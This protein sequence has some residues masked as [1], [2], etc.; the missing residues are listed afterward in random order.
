MA[1]SEA[2]ESPWRRPFEEVRRALGGRRD[3]SGVVGSINWLRKQM[4]VRGANPN[5]VRNIIYRD[6]GKVADKR[7]L[8]AVLGELWVSTGKPPLRAPELELLLSAPPEGERE[9]LLLGREKRRVYAGFVGAVRAGKHPKLL[10]TG[11]QGS[12]KTLLIDYIQG[13]LEGLAEMSGKGVSGGGAS[14][15]VVRQEFSAADLAAGLLQLALAFGVSTEVFGAKLA[16][17]GVAGAYAVQ[18]DAQADV[19][20]VVLEHLKQPSEPLTLLLHVSQSFSGGQDTLLGAPLRLSTPDVPR[21]AMTEWLW[22]TLLEPVSRLTHVGLLV[23]MAD[24]PLTLAGRTDAFD[25]PVKLSPPTVNEARRFV[26]GRAQH[27]SAEQQEALVGRAKRSFEDL[28]TLTLLAEAREP[29]GDGR[30]TEQLGQL[31][32]SSSDAR[33]KDFL[34]VLAVLALPEYPAVAQRDLEALREAEPPALN[35]LEL[36]FLDAVP[37]EPGYWRP[38]ARLFSRTLRR[39]LK[40]A[41]PER[42]RS[43][44]LAASRLYADTAHSAPRSDAAGRFVHHLFAAR[45]WPELNAWAEETAVPQSLL[46]RLWRAAQLELQPHNT[47]TFEA[48]ALQVANYYV[49]L[50]SAEHPDAGQALAVLAASTD[51]KRRAW[52]LLKRAESAVLQGRF[53]HA[54]TL[55]QGWVEVDDPVLTVEAALVRANLARWHSRL[56]DAA[57]LARTG[58]GALPAAP[59]GSIPIPLPTL[60]LAVRVALWGGLAAKD[61]GD[62]E[63]ALARFEAIQTDDE[64]LRARVRFQVGGVLLQLG[65]FARA[66]AALSE[67]VAGAYRGEAPAFERARYLSRR[68]TLRRRQGAFEAAHTDFAAARAALAQAELEAGSYRLHFEEAK[69]HDERAL[70][71]LA[72]GRFS[73]AIIVLQGNIETFA[74]YGA[75][76]GVD[77]SFRILRSTLRLALAYGCRAFNQPYRLPLGPYPET[78]AAH[79]DLV[80]ARRLVREVLGTLADETNRYG[81]LK[82]A[83]HLTA[84]LLLPPEEAV[85]EAERTLALARY[86]YQRSRAQ[87]Y[88]TAALVRDGDYGRAL[89]LITRAQAQLRAAHTDDDGLWAY[90]AVLEAG[91]RCYLGEPHKAHTRTLEALAE[92][93]LRLYHDLIVRRLGEVAERFEQPLDAAALGLGGPLPTTLRPAD[94]LVMRLQRRSAHAPD[95]GLGAKDAGSSTASAT[96]LETLETG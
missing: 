45:R 38:F 54:E 24:L 94:A 51:P 91:T 59:G 75:R 85:S 36:A 18:A 4:E 73:D 30:H 66:H 79:P 39:K 72:E 88:L 96:P 69:I 10:I 46:G 53:E 35:S 12:G 25:G 40:E 64:L 22:H 15:R 9:A 26:R 78:A 32:S 82:T 41:N 27:L 89:E 2:V 13:A 17:V 6:K 20:R 16:K 34:E 42:F 49:R 31:V 11:R 68:G 44:S 8:F 43:L 93:R 5:V 95:T 76:Y 57:A 48:V 74:G 92:P 80:R 14:S 65:Q 28:R 87:A 33:L 7:V 70:S 23:S 77:P 62:L 81:N 61:E 84:S 83:A 47:P 56:S 50:G 37:G 63:G 67:A 52:T 55:L 29:L 60:A 71:E 19:A 90:L 3:A 1:V 21:V 58:L 86:P